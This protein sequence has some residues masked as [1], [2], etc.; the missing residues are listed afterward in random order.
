MVLPRGMLLCTRKFHGYRVGNTL[1]FV[2]KKNGL[3]QSVDAIVAGD[4]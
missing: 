1:T 4:D 2:R 3:Y